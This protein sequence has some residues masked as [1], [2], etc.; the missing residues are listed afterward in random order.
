M[1]SII[2]G[3]TINMVALIFFLS[4]L[5]FLVYPPLIAW[6]Q[7]ELSLA[8]RWAGVA[9]M[10]LMIPVYYWMFSNLGDNITPTVVTRE[11]HQ[12]ITTGQA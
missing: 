3:K 6:A 5:G 1:A 11:D 2:L 7:V 12:L 8:L 9:I 10:A 4:L